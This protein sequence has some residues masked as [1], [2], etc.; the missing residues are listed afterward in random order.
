MRRISQYIL[1]LII[2]VIIAIIIIFSYFHLFLMASHDVTLSLTLS[3]YYLVLSFRM[4]RRWS[5]PE[6]E[7]LSA[8]IIKTIEIL[9]P[10]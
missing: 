2:I 3:L 7:H 5:C 4:T 10:G 1:F 8:T 6:T 9:T